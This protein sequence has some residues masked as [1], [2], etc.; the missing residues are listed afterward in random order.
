MSGNVVD[1]CPVGAL[2]DKDFLYKQRVWFMKKHNGVCASCSTGCSIYVEENQ[3]AV[4]RLKPRDN[5]F[6]NGHWM[7]DEGRYNYAYIHR[8]DRLLEPRR[9]DDAATAP[10]ASSP[11]SA[12][13]SNGHPPNS[14]SQN[15]LNVEWSQIPRLL[16]AQL[17][18]KNFSGR[19]GVVIS[20]YQTVEDAYLLCKLARSI[21]S[22]AV[23]AMGP[24][25]VEGHDERFKSGFIIH[26]EKCPNRHGV[27][28]V[29]E[30][31]G[32]G[33]GA[34]GPATTWEQFL[35]S[36][37]A[38]E[39]TAAWV[40]AGYRDAWIDEATA[41]RFDPLK[42]LIVHD[43]FDSPLWQRATFQ[44]P[45][46]GY[47]ERSGSYVNYQQRLQS[48]KWAI[49]PPAGVHVEGHLFWQLLGMSGMYNARAV[50]DEVAGEIPYFAAAMDPVPATGVDLRVNS[51]AGAVK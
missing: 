39:I 26:A 48:F 38:S 37:D 47:A 42:L 7:C 16:E 20:P 40:V 45:G 10:S 2:G 5:Q 27:E 4:Y 30:H 29:L 41:A 12:T 17:A 28:A 3:D 6:I 36:L 25:P 8:A 9:R 51:L 19:L 35:S 1:L 13:P 50:L 15:Y 49:R 14:H 44:L 31:F 21:D 18:G 32:D 33:S 22:N 34:R 24:V 46:A 11:R 23:L 43:L